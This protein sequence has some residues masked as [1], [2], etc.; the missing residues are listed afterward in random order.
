[1]CLDFSLIDDELRLKIPPENEKSGTLLQRIP[2]PFTS[3]GKGI[4]L[5]HFVHEEKRRLCYGQ[6]TQSLLRGK[7]N[8]LILF[9]GHTPN[10]ISPR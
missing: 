9:G 10:T 6:H 5:H 3:K 2:I 4:C 7:N 8:L 1:M